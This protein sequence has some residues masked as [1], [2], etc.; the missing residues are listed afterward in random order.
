MRASNDLQRRVDLMERAVDEISSVLPVIALAMKDRGK[1]SLDEP[2]SQALL[3][4]A[5]R[6]YFETAGSALARTPDL[7]ETVRVSLAQITL[8]KFK[9]DLDDP[10]QLEAL[11]ILTWMLDGSP[12]AKDIVSRVTATFKEVGS[13]QNSYLTKFWIDAA[14][15]HSL[16]ANVVD[17]FVE[18]AR[19]GTARQ[20]LEF[21]D[22]EIAR[23]L[24]H[25]I[26]DVPDDRRDAVYHL[27]ERVE[28]SITPIS[29][30]LADILR[31]ARSGG[32]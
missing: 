11:H 3:E 32:P 20:E 13:P 19:T 31:L 25:A 4:L 28:S 30:T 26:A 9:G 29:E 1:P 21:F 7:N 2:T 24:A 23:V 16:P 17:D 10:S 15:A 18:Q 6:G 27:V 5:K 12:N 22:N 8:S 14:D